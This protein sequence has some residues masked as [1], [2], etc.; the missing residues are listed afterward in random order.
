MLDI[1]PNPISAP[2][3][4]TQIVVWRDDGS[5][6]SIVVVENLD[7]SASAAIKYQENDGSGW[8]DLFGT[9]QTINPGKSNAQILSMAT[10]RDLA[11]YASGNVALLFTLI[12][13]NDGQLADLGNSY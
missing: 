13:Q 12:R 5:I 7:G 8:V 3:V 11:L 6:P 10:E 9:P 1:K 4:G 2:A